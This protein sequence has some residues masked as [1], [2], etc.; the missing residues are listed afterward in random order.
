MHPRWGRQAQGKS[1]IGPSRQLQPCEDSGSHSCRRSRSGQEEVRISDVCMHAKSFQLCSTL[2]NPMD[3]N[4]PG[5]SVLGIFQVSI[6]EWVAMP[7]SR[8][9]SRLQGSDP[10]LLCLLNWQADSLPLRHLGSPKFDTPPRQAIKPQFPTWQVGIL[11]TILI[12]SGATNWS[13]SLH[14][15]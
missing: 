3:C 1:L 10:H 9:S 5:S 12:R 7:S 6:L 13:P 2:C 15:S 4:L 14:L 8:R 11:T